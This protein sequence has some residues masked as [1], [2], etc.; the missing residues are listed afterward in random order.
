MLDR[1]RCECLIKPA[2]V[3]PS[4]P[5]LKVVS[6]FNPGVVE[7]DGRIVIVARVAEAVAEVPPGKFALPRWS[8]GGSAGPELVIDR[9][10]ES[11]VEPVDPRVVKIRRT[12]CCRLTFTSHLRIIQTD[13]PFHVS[14]QAIEQATTFPAADRHEVFGVEDPRIT[15]I[16]DRYYMT[17]VAV[18][19][20]GPCTALASTRDFVSFERHGVIFPVENKD[21]TLFPEKIDGRYLAMHRPVGHAPFTGPEIWLGWSDNL[22]DW[23]RHQHLLGPREVAE[24][25]VGRVGGGCPPIRLDDHW[26][27]IYHGN[28][29]Q[30]GNSDNQVGAYTAVA[31][32]LDGQDPAR[33]LK[34]TDGPIMRPSEPFE[35][36]GFVPDVVF[37]TG[38]VERD[39]QLIVYYGAAD[40]SIG[41][42][43]WS[44]DQLRAALNAF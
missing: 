1:L 14:R 28:D 32:L 36:E 13:D 5:R 34:H 22:T 26:L 44:K 39:D 2:D 17:Y 19:E 25:G 42:V 24:W 33:I 35:T 38:L 7:V 43:A 9:L 18:S 37:P 23:G 4:D 21:V 6:V 41:V 20:H 8:L 10:D 11:E 12:H 30:P 15:K 40:E 3:P 29:K 16:G 31:M 27:V